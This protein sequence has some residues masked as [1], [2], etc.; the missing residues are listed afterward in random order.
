MKPVDLKL[1]TYIN[2]SREINN[3]DPTF[4]IGDTVRTSKYKNIFAKGNDQNCS[5]E[6]FVIKEVKNTVLWTYIISDLNGEEIVGMF[7]EKELQKTNQKK[8]RV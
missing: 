6:A 4:K 2:S 7:Y 8:F 5:E 1:N 3:D